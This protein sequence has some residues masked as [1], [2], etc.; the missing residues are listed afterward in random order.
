[1][2]SPQHLTQ[3]G[4][5]V[6]H[7]PVH[8]ARAARGGEA[9]ARSDIFAFGCVLYEM[10]TGKKAFDGKSQASLI[11]SILKDNP[12]PASIDRTDDAARAR[13]ASW[14]PVSRRTRRI[15]SRRRTTSSCSFSGSPRA[16]RR[17]A[18]RPPSRH[19]GRAASA[20]PG[21]SRRGRAPRAR[22]RDR[23]P[24]PRARPL[25]IVRF[26][27]AMPEGVTAID[28]P[29]ISPDGRTL[30]FN[31]TD[32]TGKSRLWVRALNALKAHPLEGTE[33]RRAPSGRPTAGSSAFSPRES[34]RRST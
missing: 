18:F 16:A 8:V 26:D 4:T 10:A 11:G 19:G 2:A 1:M 25:R 5:I 22:I 27:I 17:S 15:A 20:S 32:S 23:L 29:R 21:L 12:P 31:A 34:S 13:P 7:V 24:S 30:A 33:G 3:Q 9:D 28:A 6:G 14:R